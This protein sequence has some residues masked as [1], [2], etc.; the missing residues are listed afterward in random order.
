VIAI[1]RRLPALDRV[2]A[3][4]AAAYFAWMAATLLGWPVPGVVGD[5]AFFPLGLVI[6]WA[7][8]RNSRVDWLDGRT[9]LAWRLLA[10]AAL[11]LWMSGSTWTIWLA[12][13]GSPEY[14]VWIDRVAFA[15]YVLAIAGYL[16]FPGRTLPRK[17]GPRFL[18]DVALIVVAGFVIAFYVGLRLLLHDPAE[19]A[20]L[21]IVESSLDWALFVVAAVGCMQKRDPMI[22]RVLI[23]L[24][25]S[26]LVSLAGNYWLATLPTY[27]NGHPIDAL[28]FSAWA[29]RWT[30]ARLAWHH[31]LAVG[32]GRTPRTPPV[33]D[34]RS[35]PFSH[36][37]VAGAFVL[38]LT[39]ILAHNYAFIGMLAIAAMLLGAL[40]ILRQFAEL[41]ENRRLFEG[42]LQEES[43]FKSLVQHSSDVVIV[44]D[45]G[46]FV[47]Y[48]SP[49]VASVFGEDG[50]VVPGAPFRTLL[51]Q[52]G[53]AIADLLVAGST[54]AP[55]RFE[56]AMQVAPGRWREIEAAWTDLRGDPA[57][58][59]ILIDCRDVSER[60]EIE[61]HLRQSQ[62]LD[63]VGH[64]AGGLAHDLNNFLSVIRGYSEILRADLPAGSPASADLDQI[65]RAVDRAAAVTGKVLAFSRKQPGQMKILDLNGVVT[66]LEP[67]LRQVIKDQVEVRLELANGLWPVRA[68]QG[69]M[70]QVVVNLSTNARDAMPDG[71]VIRITTTNRTI[72]AATTEPGAVPP[73]DCVSLTVSDQGTGMSPALI[74]R[75]FEP[76][77]STKSKD[78]GIGLGLSIVHG[79]VTDVGG[80][81][82]VESAEGR[83]STFTMLLPRAQ[84]Q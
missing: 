31:Y 66:G 3:G 39:Q 52:D 5:I 79:I 18:L 38:L 4:Y 69:Q 74:A 67:M 55:H 78:R 49:S 7:N 54:N 82:V 56:A 53:A 11:V 16:S 46:G 76:F 35:N 2:A 34:Y 30:A 45:E 9:R 83:G 14:A 65:L 57:V 28:W 43:R 25:A 64:L 19:S 24:L 36:I 44:V 58:G 77:F 73:G 26:N 29:L 8:W 71:G 41:E 80:R 27:H 70:E 84:P 22:R 47:T 59:G 10:L 40:L 32:E 50:Q 15:Q 13:G 33:Q 81:V 68:D 37:L 75:I 21:A 6:A 1:V 42:R 23:L 51:A 20:T 48:V 17:S 60:N 63:A 61:R 72:A 62:K 12:S